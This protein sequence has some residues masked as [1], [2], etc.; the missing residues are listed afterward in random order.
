VLGVGELRLECQPFVQRHCSAEAGLDA[1]AGAQVFDSGLYIVWQ[2]L[3]GQHHVRP[4][5]VAAYRRAFHT[6]QHTPHGRSLTPGGIGVPGIFIAVVG[7]VRA[8][9]D[10]HQPRVLRVAPGHRVVLQLAEATGEGHVL[11]TAE[12]LVAQEQHTVLEQ[13]LAQLGEQ[14]VIVNRIGQVDA[15]HLSTDRAG[16]LFN[17]HAVALFR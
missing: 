13:L 15:T 3:I 6:A 11:G 14:F 1:V 2:V 7:L 16:Q 17:V 5:G 4:Q 10:L 8:L 12:V 9:V